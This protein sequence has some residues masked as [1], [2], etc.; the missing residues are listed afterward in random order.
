MKKKI[1]ITTLVAIVVCIGYF[2]TLAYQDKDD[3]RNGEMVQGEEVGDTEEP[4][5]EIEK[6][7]APIVE[8]TDVPSMETTVPSEKP[9]EDASDTPSKVPTVTPSEEPTVVP[10]EQ[11]KTEE[12]VIETES[13]VVET[14]EPTIEPTKAFT[15]KPV[16]TKTPTKA[17]TQKPTV[18]P[19]AKPSK[20][21]STRKPVVGDGYICP[22]TG[23]WF[24]SEE[25]YK[26][27][28][29]EELAK[30]TPTPVPRTELE[31]TESKYYG[32]KG[33]YKLVYDKE[34]KL[35]IRNTIL[36]LDE[37]ELSDKK[38]EWNFF[39]SKEFNEVVD[40]ISNVKDPWIDIRYLQ[41][42]SYYVGY[43][44]YDIRDFQFTAY[45]Y[46]SDGT[47][48]NMVEFYYDEGFNV[49]EG[50]HPALK[51]DFGGG[52]HYVPDI[53]PSRVEVDKTKNPDYYK[54]DIVKF[55]YYED[56]CAN[57]RDSIFGESANY[58]EIFDFVKESKEFKELTKDA[59][60]YSYSLNWIFAMDG[61][62]H[63]DIRDYEISISIDDGKEQVYYWDDNYDMVK[64]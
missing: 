17:P 28:C 33:K 45:Q 5:D 62:S 11:P 2:V 32:R 44:Y 26:E 34:G 9:Q 23:K 46:N 6:T 49:V 10:T 4:A 25:A 51:Y 57:L 13:P 36:G 41:E 22:Y 18:K 40:N 47:F 35:D 29:K 55:V 39:Y 8:K 43:P 30:Q 31:K 7:L 59:R 16:V 61:E 50:E 19:T 53:D 56:G 27:W 21:P 12:L 3:V 52:V 54:K 38:E 63:Y 42:E 48:A 24:E 1:L 64:K 60:I 14:D 58:Q 20:A 37:S 15:K